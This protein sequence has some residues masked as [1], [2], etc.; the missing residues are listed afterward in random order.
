MS[1]HLKS[2]TGFSSSLVVADEA[3]NIDRDVIVS[4]VMPQTVQRE[5][6]QLVMCSTAGDSRSDLVAHYR[7]MAQQPGSE[8]LLLEWSA[9]PDADVD[10][11][12]A[13]RWSLPD[14]RPKVYR[15]LRQVTDETAW[16]MQYLNQWV[17]NRD[18]WVSLA[19]WLPLRDLE[20][21]PA[22]GVVVVGPSRDY[23]SWHAVHASVDELGVTH[24]RQTRHTVSDRVW[25]WAHDLGD[26][27]ALH[28]NVGT[29]FREPDWLRPVAGTVGARELH[30]GIR[31]VQQRIRDGGVRHDGSELLLQHVTRASVTDLP[32]GTTVMRSP[33][34]EAIDL[35]ESL[36][37][38]VELAGR[39]MRGPVLV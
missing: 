32:G 13:W 11:E 28:V 22:G 9:P 26:D 20:G 1:N 12:D 33:T 35:C 10:D 2:V 7:D 30:A 5:Q 24:V 3:W 21:M 6:P 16:R 18:G 25:R 17:I 29:R 19:Q 37:V 39:T 23:S 8:V 38:A 36:V 34:G 15:R 31:L 4:G 27:V 14:W